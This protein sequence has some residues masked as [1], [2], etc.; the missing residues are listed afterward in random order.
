MQREGLF[1]G[2]H[3]SQNC[4]R[5]SLIPATSPVPTTPMGEELSSHC[6]DGAL[7][8]GPKEAW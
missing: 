8:L 7:H 4:Q 5:G 1:S 2:S 6:T 3:H